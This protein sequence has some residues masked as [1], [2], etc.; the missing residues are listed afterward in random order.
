MAYV[1]VAGSNN[2]WEYENTATKSDEDTYSDSN[3]TIADC[4]RS[5]TSIGGNTERVYIK[6]RKIGETIIRGELNKNYYDNL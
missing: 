5:F 6:C 2:I 1:T 3:G 4:I